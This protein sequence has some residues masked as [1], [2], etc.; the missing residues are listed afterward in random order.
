MKNKALYILLLFC[1]QWMVSSCNEDLLFTT[2]PS[3]QGVGNV[4]FNLDFK[5]MDGVAV[6]SRAQGDTIEKINT[7]R[8]VIYKEGKLFMNQKIEDFTLPK[9]VNTSMAPGNPETPPADEDYAQ[10]ETYR[11]TFDLPDL[12]YG[13]YRIYA[14]VNVRDLSNDEVETE[15]KLRSVSCTWN[16]GNVAANNQMFGMF[17]DSE[18]TYSDNTE[19]TINQKETTLH[20]WVKRLASKVT[21]AYDGSRLNE[22]IFI[23]LHTAQIKDIPASCYLGKSNTPTDRDNQLIRDGETLSYSESNETLSGL[24]VTKGNPFHGSEHTSS[25]EALFFYENMQGTDPEKHQYQN[26]DE[27]DNKLCGTYIE[28]KGYYV[29]KSATNPSEGNIVYR[30]MLGKN[31][32]DDFNAERNNHYKLT[33]CFKNDAN[34]P[35]WHIEYEVEPGLSVPTPLYISYLYHEKLDIPVVFSGKNVTN[36]EAKI[37]MNNWGYEGHKYYNKS[38]L[39]KSGVPKNEYGFLSL[40][41]NEQGVGYTSSQTGYAVT[42]QDESS[43]KATV[44]VYTRDLTIGS[45]VSG[46]NNFVEHTRSATVEISATIDDTS[47][48]KRVEVIQ[49]KR[50]VNPAGIWRPGNSM[51][52]FHVTLMEQN[53]EGENESSPVTFIPTISDG[54]W[55]ATIEKGSEWVQIA[56]HGSTVWNTN[57]I[58]GS[59]GSKIEFNYRPGS[60]YT[61]TSTRCG[62]IKI[63]YHNNMCV[64]RIFVSQ[65]TGTVTMGNKKWHTCNVLK[66]GEDVANPLLEGSMFKYGNS[67]DA[68]LSENNL[69]YPFRVEPKGGLFKLANNATKTWEQITTPSRMI[70]NQGFTNLSV[71]KGV[72][73]SHAD[74][75][76]LQD[77]D[78]AY[79]V[80]YGEECSETLSDQSAYWY[81]KAGEVKGM[82]GCF[83]YD[84]ATGNSIFFPIGASGYGHREDW[85]CIVTKDQQSPPNYHAVLKYAQ[86]SLEM[87]ESVAKGVPLYYDLWKRAGAVYWYKNGA[88]TQDNGNHWKYAWDINYFTY[89]FDTYGENPF[90]QG[91]NTSAT[92]DACFIRCVE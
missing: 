41:E 92:S 50:V 36:V 10:D 64:H 62:I 1:V 31:V 2:D 49:V 17:T 48:S 44:P 22:N 7:L 45:S 58:T 57:A 26:Y 9:S 46:N 65:G 78:R 24:C 16:S 20:A 53:V 3:G 63:T 30:F 5:S 40:K 67:D 21:V 66:N 32:T 91:D 33:L 34:N 35:D 43:F 4:S 42:K 74:W 11:T 15:E 79:G 90:T 83:V 18:D 13:I 47:Y 61:G 12:P 75:V 89:G 55:T 85:D 68:I 77:K 29:N 82:R 54:P 80:L 39:D 25:D 88:G 37:I 86:R 87:P 8:I 19:V 71:G 56:P 70:W 69:T 84:K 76:A 27:K 38:N 23:Y 72:P 6:G 51:K 81:M 52:P 73:S 60:K 59:T 28:V 14:V